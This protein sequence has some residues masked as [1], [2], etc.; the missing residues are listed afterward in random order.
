MVAGCDQ[1]RKTAGERTLW[2][3]HCPQ[4]FSKSLGYVWQPSGKVKQETVSVEQF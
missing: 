3:L 4:T 1:K 2:P